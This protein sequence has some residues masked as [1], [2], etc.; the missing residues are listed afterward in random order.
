MSFVRSNRLRWS[1]YTRGVPANQLDDGIGRY[2]GIGLRGTEY[3]AL[4]AC[5]IHTLVVG[6]T[7]VQ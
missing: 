2:L 4:S 6:D 1:D 5:L 7:F 3:A